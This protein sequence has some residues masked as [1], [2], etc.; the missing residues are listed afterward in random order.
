M[1]SIYVAN[2]SQKSICETIFKIREKV[3]VEEQQVDASEEFD[4][5]ESTSL[6]YLGTL[7]SIP[8][9]TARWRITEKGIKLERF[10]VLP[11]FRNQ[12]IGSAILTKVLSDVKNTGVPL[13][14]HAQI[15]AIDFYSRHGFI[16]V[17]EL[18]EEC[19]IQHYKMTYGY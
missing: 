15:T 18:F 2:I 6:H 12:G 13:Y 9:G 5:F 16:K 11:E 8:A 7:N 17:G 1:I 19:G 3:F 14:L 4:S 10:A